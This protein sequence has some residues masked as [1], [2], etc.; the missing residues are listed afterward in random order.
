MERLFRLDEIETTT[1][2]KVVTLR[3]DIREGRLK[4][5]RIGRQVRIS[6]TDLLD[7]LSRSGQSHN[8]TVKGPK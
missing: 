2:R 8:K 3:R 4:A 5:T 7:F 1:R 6:E